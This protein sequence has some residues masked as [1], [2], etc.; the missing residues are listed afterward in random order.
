M[1]VTQTG[2]PYY[3]CPEVWKDKPYNSSSDIWSVGCVIYEMAALRP[4]FMAN[5][6]RGLF[7]KVTKGVFPPIPSGY[8]S[9]LSAIISM[10]L[11]VNPVMRPSCQRILDMDIVK[12]HT[13]DH[14]SQSI[15]N[16]L[17]GTIK[18]IPSLKELNNRLPAPNY[19]KKRGRGQSI[20]HES[21]R[22][23]SQ[24]RIRPGVSVENRREYR[25]QRVPGLP[26]RY[27]HEYSEPQRYG[28]TDVSS[29]KK[30]NRQ[31]SYV[32]DKR[33][34]PLLQAGANVLQSEVSTPKPSSQKGLFDRVGSDPAL[35][36]P[37][38][39]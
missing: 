19:E 8:S 22:S 2:T 9:D 18:Y 6:M 4:P 36:R 10:M 14:Q 11:Q 16:D 17:L 33:N 24:S 39:K 37:R 20:G 30:M 1:A 35:D 12:R 15:N 3:A 38:Y 7:D 34:R 21:E 26:P 32:D 13:G 29:D 31:N 28:P 27:K 5:D 25:P 23:D